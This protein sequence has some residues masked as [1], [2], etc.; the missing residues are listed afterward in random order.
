MKSTVIPFLSAANVSPASD[1]VILAECLHQ[2]I[3]E[4][5]LQDFALSLVDIEQV[6]FKQAA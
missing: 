3:D 1:G 4:F 5:G 2:T 6:A